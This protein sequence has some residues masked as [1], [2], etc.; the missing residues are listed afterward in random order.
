MTIHKRL[1]RPRLQSLVIY[2]RAQELWDE[3]TR[4]KKKMF[5]KTDTKAAPWVIIDADQKDKARIKAIERI[6]ETI[7]YQKEG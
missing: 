6:L 2:E 7:P 5:K 3:Y 1:L 4:Y